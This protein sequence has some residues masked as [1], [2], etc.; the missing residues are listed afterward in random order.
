MFSPQQHPRW[1]GEHVYELLQV[2]Y[3]YIISW[4]IFH[5]SFC[6]R[7]VLWSVETRSCRHCRS[8]EPWQVRP[9]SCFGGFCQEGWMWEVSS[10]V[11]LGGQ[12]S[13]KSSSFP[14]PLHLLLHLLLL[15][16]LLYPRLLPSFIRVLAAPTFSQ[17][18]RAVE[19]HMVRTPGLCSQL[20][21]TQQTSDTN[22][23]LFLPLPAPVTV[24]MTVLESLFVLLVMTYWWGCVWWGGGG[25]W[26]LGGG[27]FLFCCSASLF[28]FISNNLLFKRCR[29]V[30]SVFFYLFLF[31]NLNFRKEKPGYF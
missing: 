23:L 13:V 3:F 18:L 22:Q 25:R 29:S 27:L 17:R 19:R 15:L 11:F 8:E 1:R 30:P 4:K 20:T 14:E 24:N 21:A 6:V 12:F 2:K 9:L 16:L 26:C 28:F 31:Q 5:R 7:A 10:C